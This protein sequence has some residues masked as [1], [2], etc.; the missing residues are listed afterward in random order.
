MSESNNDENS[1]DILKLEEEISNFFE[2]FMYDRGG[3]PL[4]GRI[5]ALCVLTSTTKPLLQKDLVDK[6]NVNPSTISRN[7]KEL[8]NWRLVDRRREPG[9]REWKY[10]VEPTSFFELLVKNIEDNSKVLQ[11]RAEDLKRIRGHWGETLSSKTKKTEEGRR[12][13]YVL[14]FLIEWIEMV[15]DDLD[16]FIDK[17]HSSFLNIE[18]KYKEIK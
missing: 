1:Q 16:S 3:S 12:A 13:L 17:L 10:Q 4:L 11:E 7:L 8:E 18:A 5:Y 6:F 14:D 9:S 15:D 2:D